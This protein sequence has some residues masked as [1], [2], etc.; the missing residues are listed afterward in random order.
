MDDDHPG[1]FQEAYIKYSHLHIFEAAKIHRDIAPDNWKD[2]ELE[3]VCGII[4]EAI[5]GANVENRY[6]VCA[7]VH[8][9]LTVMT[10]THLLAKQQE[11][12]KTKEQNQDLN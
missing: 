7:A 4:T 3:R 11:E 6:V 2:E 12:N 9:M 1:E 5:R 8:I 10:D